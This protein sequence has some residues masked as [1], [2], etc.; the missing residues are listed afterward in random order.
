MNVDS[1]S[2]FEVSTCPFDES[3]LRLDLQRVVYSRPDGSPL[4]AEIAD[5]IARLKQ[6]SGDQSIRVICDL[7]DAANAALRREGWVASV[8]VPP[9]EITD[10]TLALHVVTAKMVEVRVRGNAGPYEDMLRERLNRLKTFDPLNEGVI[11]RLLLLAGDVPGLDVQL[12]LRPAG[13]APGEVIGDVTI[14]YRR[15]N[16]LANL[17][18]YNS[19]VLGR[20][21]GYV[22]AEYYGLT[23]LSDITYVGASSTA[24]FKE[25]RIL[26]A[27]HIAGLGADGSTL[28]ARI[29]FA[30]SRPDLPGLDYRADTLIVGFDYTKP[31]IRSLNTNVFAAAGFDYIDQL[32]N[33]YSGDLKLPLTRDKMRIAYLSLN[34]DTRR[35]RPDGSPIWA[36]RG[37]LEARKGFDILGA[38]KPGVEDGR[39]QSRIDGEADALVLR[40]SLEAMAGLS[41]TFRLVARGQTQWTDDPLLN[42]EEFSLGNLTMGRGYDP[43]ANGGDR[44]IGLSGEAQFD[45]PFS[46]RFTSQVFGFYDFVYLDNLDR[47]ATETERTLSSFGAGLRLG[48]PGQALLE[49]TYAHPKDRALTIDREPPSDR[50]LVSLSLRFSDAVR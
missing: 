9:Q 34:A 5:V 20:E 7:R 47:G 19:R 48:L 42:Y 13:G 27:G 17:Q 38:T 2:A 49:I 6:P 44:A 14:S 23:G 30:W 26:Q 37:A 28:G 33:L 8:Q 35:V 11:E 18:N 15:F 45:L 39:I 16:L 3:P 21:T 22:R 46:S 29:S 1:R 50:I 31:L 43:G 32:T 12:A 24:D 36:F 40:A 4:P 25:Q 10:G 41:R